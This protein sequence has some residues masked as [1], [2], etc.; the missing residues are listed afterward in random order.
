MSHEPD[1]FRSMTANFPHK[2]QTLSLE[3]LC[4]FLNSKE[5]ELKGTPE[6]LGDSVRLDALP[7][8]GEEPEDT[9]GIFSWDDTN[10]L[11][12]ENCWVLVPRGES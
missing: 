3:E 1:S 8:F 12:Y 5:A 4:N 9:E 7:T 6:K 10:F 11:M 2:I